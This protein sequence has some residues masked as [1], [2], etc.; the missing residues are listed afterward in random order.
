[1]VGRPCRPLRSIGKAV[2]AYTPLRPY[3]V[4]GARFLASRKAALLADDMGLGKTAQAVA[5]C[6]EVGAES[7]L[8]I[9]PASVCETWRRE[10]KR[11]SMS[12][13]IPTVVSYDAL[14]RNPFKAW[15]DVLILDEA[16]Y[17]KNADSK[18]T[19]TIFGTPDNGGLADHAKHIFLLTGTPMPNN[20][21]ELWPALHALAPE[22]IVSTKTGKPYPFWQFVNKFCRTRDNGFGLQIIGGKNHSD[23]KARLEPFMLRRLK[24]E[25]LAELPPIQFEPL[26]VEGTMPRDEQ[27]LAEEWAAAEVLRHDGIEGLAKVALPTLRRLTGLAKVPACVEWI[28]DFLASGR[29]LVVF[30]HHREVIEAIRDIVPAAVVTGDTPSHRRFSAVDDFQNGTAQ[31]FLGQIQAAG[32]GIT[33]TAASDVL[34]VESDWVPANVQQAAARIHRHGQTEPCMV[35]FATLAGSVDE[36]IE[37]ALARKM[38]DIEKIVG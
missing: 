37:R 13:I 25:V 28:K 1:M 31:V 23:L 34:F 8:V 16:H 36:D 33:L 5:A 3:Q 19:R 17:L 26:Y 10:F 32:T 30:A 2:T 24:S 9:C 18:R 21:A 6:D 12:G 38:T 29:Q 35:R 15:S 7:V 22:T 20:P 11:F 27:A 14:V 4:D